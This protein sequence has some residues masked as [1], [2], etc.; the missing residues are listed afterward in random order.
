MACSVFDRDCF[1]VKIR[2]T[3]DRL[4]RENNNDFAKIAE[5]LAAAAGN[6]SNGTL[7]RPEV[8]AF[9]RQSG[10]TDGKGFV[11]DKVVK[12]VLD[13]IDLDRDGAITAQEWARRPRGD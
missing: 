9:V 6:T 11:H 8:D 7:R 2:D 3:F 12:G 1:K 4:D 10:T 13:K 5:K